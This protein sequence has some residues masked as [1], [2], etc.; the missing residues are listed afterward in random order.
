MIQCFYTDHDLQS[1]HTLGHVHAS[2]CKT[3]P[4]LSELAEP[5]A[6]KKKKKNF[7]PPEQ[8][9]EHFV[10]SVLMGDQK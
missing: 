10:F 2:P 3:I 4:L 7:R 9:E 8:T 5:R 6:L 1:N